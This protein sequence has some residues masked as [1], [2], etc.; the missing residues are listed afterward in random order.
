MIGSNE[1]A[2]GGAL[3]AVY[4]QSLPSTIFKAKSKCS[5]GLS[6][7]RVPGV[8]HTRLTSTKRFTNLNFD[9]IVIYRGF[10]ISY[11]FEYFYHNA[12]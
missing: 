4:I 6:S 12:L 7:L 11:E 1:K 8:P 5:A 3:G 10:H 9:V 2:V